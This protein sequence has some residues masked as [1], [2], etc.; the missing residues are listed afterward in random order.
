MDHGGR[1][2]MEDSV[3]SQEVDLCDTLA[4][5]PVNLNELAQTQS[6]LTSENENGGQQLSTT[7]APFNNNGNYEQDE[8]D[9]NDCTS[10]TEE[11]HDEVMKEEEDDSEESSLICCQSPDTPMTDSSY[12]ETG[13]LQETPFGFS[14]GTSPEPAPPASLMEGSEKQSQSSAIDLCYSDTKTELFSAQSVSSSEQFT[15]S[16]E[17]VLDHKGPPAIVPSAASFAE[18]DV[19]SKHTPTG[20]ET[21]NDPTCT[22]KIIMNQKPS[23]LLGFLDQ[24]AKGG[25]DKHLPQY[26]HQIAEAFVAQEDYQRAILCIQLERLYHQRLLDNLSALQK[27]WETRCNT[28]SPALTAQPLDILKHI[29]LTHSRPTASNAVVSLF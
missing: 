3:M 21:S 26:L 24:L 6:R 19:Q 18:S 17:T 29:C 13:S 28:T 7:R 12:S 4:V 2:G 9:K 23:E 14:P 5:A 10:Q 20:I 22:T 27:Q 15:S 11:D 8:Q 1:F 25:D 16:Q